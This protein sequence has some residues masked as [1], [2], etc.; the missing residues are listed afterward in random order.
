MMS[1][2]RKQLS[3]QSMEAILRIRN[4]GATLNDSAYEK[5]MEMFLTEYP[6]GD[7]RKGKRR[8]SG[9]EKGS[10]RQKKEKIKRGLTLNLDTSSEDES[11]DENETRDLEIRPGEEIDIDT[12]S[13]DESSDDDDDIPISDDD[14][15]F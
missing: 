9:Y 6:N 13:S 12:D 7:I 3:N 1:S 11:E 2:D 15:A 5:A 10:P 4:Y 14:D 8:V